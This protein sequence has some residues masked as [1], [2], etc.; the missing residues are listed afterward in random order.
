MGDDWKKRL[1][2]EHILRKFG[3]SIFGAKSLDL[4]RQGPVVCDVGL[5]LSGHVFGT[6]RGCG[7]VLTA[8]FA[9][10]QPHLLLLLL[11][12]RTGARRRREPSASTAPQCRPT[13]PCTAAVLASAAT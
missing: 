5:C 6:D 7:N 1:M 2:R 11:L 8:G 10:D 12:P 9:R 4:S 3:I 13:V